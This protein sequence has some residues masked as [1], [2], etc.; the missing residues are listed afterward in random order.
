MVHRAIDLIHLAKQSDIEILLNEEQLQLKLPRNKR[1]SEGLLKDLKDNKQLIIDFLSAHKKAN[2]NYDKLDKID[3]SLF[4]RIPLSFS[5]ERLLFIDRLE[6]SV[7]YHIPAVLML[8]GKLNSEALEYA[9]QTIVMRHEVLRT[10]I[11]EEEGNAYQHIKEPHGWAF[12]LVDGSSYK[13]D[14]IGLQLLIDN[15]IHVSCGPRY[16]RRAGSCAGG[17][18]TPYCI[19]WLVDVCVGERGCRAIQFIRR[20]QA[21]GVGSATNSVCRLCNLAAKVFGRR[22]V[23]RN[24]GVLEEKTLGCFAPAVA[25]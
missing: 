6:G 3:R 21:H 4:N 24:D 5:Q 8:K 15:I 1:I 17:N 10:V 13:E 16:Y 14:R 22:D 7:Q 25:I 11:L 20:G 19:R 23:E 2:K 12:S 9:L 18:Y